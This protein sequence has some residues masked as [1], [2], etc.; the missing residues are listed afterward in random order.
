MKLFFTSV[1]TT[2][3][4]GIIRVVAVVVVV[5]WFDQ[6]NARSTLNSVILLYDNNNNI[7][8]LSLF[9]KLWQFLWGSW[10]GINFWRKI[11]WKKITTST[12]WERLLAL[13]VPRTQTNTGGLHNTAKGVGFGSGSSLE[14]V[15]RYKRVL[16]VCVVT[17]FVV[18]VFTNLMLLLLFRT[19]KFVF[20]LFLDQVWDVCLLLGR[21]QG[22]DTEKRRDVELG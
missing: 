12:N 20:Q 3:G 1:G 5:V 6:W 18:V 16:V 11:I 8:P 17:L 13:L 15:R 19:F 10:W 4:Q 22:A 14:H 7:V 21:G 2:R 9:S